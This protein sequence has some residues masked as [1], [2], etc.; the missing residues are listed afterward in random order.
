MEPQEKIRGPPE[1]PEAPRFPFVSAT[2]RSTVPEEREDTVSQCAFLP[3]VLLS[4]LLFAEPE[5]PSRQKPLVFTHV[6]VIDA[7]GAPAQPDRTVVITGNRIT[8]LGKTGQVA[9]PPDAR[10]VDG[11][12]QFLVPGLWDMHVHIAGQSYLPLFLANGVTGVREMHAFFPDAILQMRQ[13]VREGKLL[14]PRLIA[15][16]A[17][18]DGEKP[19]WPGSLTARNAEEGRQA[20]QSLQKRGADFIKVYSKLPRPAYLA[21]AEEAKKVGLPF[22]GHVP[23]A[24][25]AAEAS[26]AGQKSFEHLYGIMLACS[27]DEEKLRKEELDTMT[28]LDNPAIRTL[29]GRTQ[30]KSLDSYSDAKARA[31]F[32][33]FVKNGTWQTP[34]LTVLR[35]LASLDDEKFTQDSRV[36]YMPLYI[37]SGWKPN[38]PPAALAN[39]KRTYKQALRLVTAMYRTGVPFLAGTDVTNPYCFP[40]F[41]LHDEL[42]LLVEESKFTPM[43]A[44]Q[45]ATRNPAKFLGLEKEL[46]TVEKGKLADLLLLDANPLDNIK[47]TRKIAAVVVNGKLLTKAELQKMLDDVEAAAGG[48]K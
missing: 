24:V 43:D 25:S 17:L 40:G 20:V 11:T 36:R 10:T 30:V 2:N 23:E 3:F 32:N 46:G 42:A 8:A 1:R 4:P 22:V 16:G 47:N 15:A 6:T 34:T 33:R 45:C 37:R 5:Q 7:T 14:G 35:A 19:F 48:K 12:G 44:L 28:K 38:L 29:M 18:V 9:L 41:S 21:I 27:T 39:L 31:L 26:D 13:Q